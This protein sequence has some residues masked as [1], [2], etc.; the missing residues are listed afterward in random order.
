[1]PDVSE[2]EA[3]QDLPELNAPKDWLNMLEGEP[4]SSKVL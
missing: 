1:M 4:S 3:L 2:L